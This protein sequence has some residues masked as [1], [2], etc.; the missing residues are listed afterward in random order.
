MPKILMIDDDQLF[1]DYIAGYVHERFP[2]LDFSTCLNPVRGLAAIDEDLALLLLDLEMPGLDGRKML[3]YAVAKGV[4]RNRIIIL[5][6]R[7][8]EYLHMQFPM[9][10]C[11]AVLNKHEMRQKAVL[12]MIFSS[13]HEKCANSV[14]QSRQTAQV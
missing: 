4:G 14:K 7:D 1:L 2:R 13:L 12:D 10:S 5:S 3:N 9:G 11:L 8:A 6:G